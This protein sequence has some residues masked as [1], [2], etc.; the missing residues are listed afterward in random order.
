MTDASAPQTKAFWLSKTFWANLLMVLSM[1]F[2]NVQK[3]AAENPEALPIIIAFVNLVLRTVT[4]QP[5]SISGNNSDDGNNRASG[6]GGVSPLLAFLLCFG[7]VFFVSPS[8]SGNLPLSGSLS[9]RDPGSGAKGGL[10][11]VPGEKPAAFF[12]APIFDPE[13]GE[14]IGSAELSGPLSTTVETTK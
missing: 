7:L 9:Y 5:I 3:W 11:F 1:I 8:C 14:Q 6:G 12:R 4:K 13:T 10:V 2:P